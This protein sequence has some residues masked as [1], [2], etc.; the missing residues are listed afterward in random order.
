MLVSSDGRFTAG[1]AQQLCQGLAVSR[2]IQESYRAFTCLCCPA[3]KVTD[4]LRTST[5][6]ENEEQGSVIVMT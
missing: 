5:E 4:Q 3:A 6:H 2:I 1:K